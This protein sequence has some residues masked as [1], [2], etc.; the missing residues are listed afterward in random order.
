[1][2]RF[3][4]KQNVFDTGGRNCASTDGATICNIDISSASIASERKL[5]RMNISV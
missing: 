2:E 4:R 3:G 5:T 1:M